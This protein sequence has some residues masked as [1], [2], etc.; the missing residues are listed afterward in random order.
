MTP[1]VR[2]DVPFTVVTDTEPISGFELSAGTGPGGGG[3]SEPATVVRKSIYWW[4]GPGDCGGTSVHFGKIY[5]RG[6]V[7]GVQ[8]L[9]SECLLP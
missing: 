2:A 9:R 1:G 7:T 6:T 4:N 8:F 5:V 3:P